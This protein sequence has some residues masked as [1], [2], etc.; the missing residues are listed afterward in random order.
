MCLC[1]TKLISF[2]KCHYYN[3]ILNNLLFIHLYLLLHPL[4]FLIFI[5]NK[6]KNFTHPKI[7]TKCCRGVNSMYRCSLDARKNSS[8]QVSRK[9]LNAFIHVK[10]MWIKAFSFFTIFLSALDWWVFWLH[11]RIPH[12]KGTD[13]WSFHTPALQH[14]FLHIF[15]C[16]FIIINL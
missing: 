2:W 9:K 3:C 4:N 5:C 8:I 7:C 10:G 11:K 16:M 12:P 15:G 14:F 1:A 6:Y 13:S